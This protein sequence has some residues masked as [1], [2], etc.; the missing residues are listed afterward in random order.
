[1]SL[2]DHNAGVCARRN[3]DPPEENWDE[4]MCECGRYIDVSAIMSDLGRIGGS[5]KGPTKR[6]NVDYAALAR[7]SHESRRIN[8]RRKSK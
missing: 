5:K 8:Q 3:D 7:L 6:R 1:M 4:P 2:E